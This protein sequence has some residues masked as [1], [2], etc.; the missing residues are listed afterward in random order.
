MGRKRRRLNSHLP[1]YVYKG[2][3]AYVYKPYI[4]GQ[5]RKEI[6]LCAL[7]AT[8]REIYEAYEAITHFKLP[9]TLS[10]LI[11]L[12]LNSDRFK[13]LSK[14]TVKSYRL[15]AKNVINTPINNGIFGD[16]LLIDIDIVVIRHYLD[17]LHKT[18]IEG[19]RR[20]AF[21]NSVYNWGIQRGYAKTNPTKGITRYTEKPRKLYVTDKMYND[22]YMLADKPWYIRPMMEL[23]YLCRMRRV[24]VLDIRK[25]DITE[26]GLRIRRVKGSNDTITNWSDRLIKAVNYCLQRESI[27]ESVYLI[28]NSKGQ[29]INDGTFTTAWGLL[30][31]NKAPKD[32]VRFSYHDLKAKG[33]SDFEGDK[34]LAG[35]HKTNA[36]VAVYDRKL[37]TV[38][39]TR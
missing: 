19:N 37:K 39:A 30:W 20:V 34:Q 14:N 36:M 28:H 6:R 29:K 7:T 13:S 3:S 5:K 23:A 26:E 10:W 38:K 8:T 24:E 27:I 22:F 21:L 11:D 17:S 2:K 32:W 9:E 16:T 31:R 25:S 15:Y 18:P 4:S 1:K 12:Y 33:V 35:G